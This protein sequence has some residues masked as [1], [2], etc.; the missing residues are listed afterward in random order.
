MQR[1][2]LEKL[3]DPR[4]QRKRLEALNAAGFGCSV[5]GDAE[6]PLHVHHRAY[7]KGREPWEYDLGQLEV[8]C[9]QCHAATHESEDVLSLAASYLPS[10]L[11][12]GRE[13]IAAALLAFLPSTAM[14]AD[15]FQ[16]VCEL[17]S[18]HSRDPLEHMGFLWIALYWTLNGVCEPGAVLRLAECIRADH[19]LFAQM[20]VGYLGKLPEEGEH[21]KPLHNAMGREQPT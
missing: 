7:F 17:S 16:K 14:P 6:S 11:P 4:W 21:Y 13:E 19:R 10:G 15:T 8:L 5:C 3:K 2:Y 18:L 20:V 1:T 12:L 9:E